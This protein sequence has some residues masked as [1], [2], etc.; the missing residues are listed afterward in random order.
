MVLCA[1]G[2]PTLAPK[3]KVDLQKNG[4]WAGQHS[5]SE[6]APRARFRTPNA[7][8][9]VLCADGPPTLAPKS[10]VD[11]Q[12]N[13]SWAASIPKAKPRHGR[14]FALHN[15]DGWGFLGN[16]VRVN[17]TPQD[18]VDAGWPEDAELLET[19]L[20]EA[21]ALQKRGIDS[22]KY[23]LKLL[24]RRFPKPNPLLTMR[25]EPLPFGEAIEATNEA[26]E[27][28]LD[29][30]RRYMRELMACPVIE[31]GAVMPDACPAGNARASVPVGGAFAAR[32]AIL[33][34]GHGSDIC[35]SLHATFFLG[36]GE[37]EVM[38][39]DV[40]TSTRFGP[41]G[42]P[43]GERVPHPVTDE[44][45]WG[46][47][48]LTGLQDHARGHMADQGDG[49]HFAFLGRVELG[50]D[51]LGRMDDAG[52]GEHV[53][54]LREMGEGRELRVLVTHHGSRGLG[55]HVYK[56]GIQAAIKQTAKIASGIPD[57]AAWLS[58]ETEE[59]AEYWEALQYVGRWTLA[60]HESIHA[61][62]LEKS[63]ARRVT[64]FGNQHNFV[65]QRGELFLHGK[66]ATPAWS[67]ESGRPL[68][69]LI[70]L[71]M[72]SP[73]L[74]VLGRDNAD[75]LSFAP[76]GAGR[77]VSRRAL[78]RQFRLKDG[79]LDT[80]AMDRI[81]EEA[82]KDIGVR[83]YLGKA[84]FSEGPPGYKPAAQVRAQIEQFQLADVIAEIEPLGSVMAGNAPRRGEEEILTPK[85]ERQ[86]QHRAERRKQRQRLRS[87]DW[88]A[89]DLTD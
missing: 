39:D 68:L 27:K 64:A 34:G 33:P 22:R 15:F 35:C 11:L 49:N 24:A 7:R 10:K 13:S 78:V 58:L 41:G 76:H 75:F 19:I 60:N 52:H 47:R 63:G 40:V 82:V 5:E 71:N 30:V 79:G 31:A 62:F 20:T 51:A 80:Q 87:N 26:D 28:N 37:T 21:K 2:P 18:L 43:P 29:A 4:S 9:V 65:W 46:N 77:N 50:A 45:V 17:L 84:D 88:D 42:R 74:L 32:N 25:S 81:L 54:A 44:P 66:G 57:A 69:G 85:Q 73:I 12:K 83:W 61:R 16:P 23:L 6:T 38:L 48:F 70:P 55:A 67:G 56:R 86:I 59:G 53:R 14:D 1:D 3:S 8:R 89:D 36:G 72:A